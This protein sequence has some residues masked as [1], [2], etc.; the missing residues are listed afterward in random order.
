VALLACGPGR[1]HAKHGGDERFVISEEA[2][3]ATLQQK[4]EVTDGGVSGQQLTIEGGI[5]CLGR[6]QLL[7]KESQWRPTFLLEL[8]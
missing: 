5:F 6:R 4:P 1:R 3:L 7:R 2:E 8:L